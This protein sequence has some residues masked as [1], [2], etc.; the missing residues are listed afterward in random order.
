MCESFISALTTGRGQRWLLTAAAVE[1]SV[2]LGILAVPAWLARDYHAFARTGMVLTAAAVVASLLAVSAAPRLAES[3]VSRWLARDTNL[4]AFLVRLTACVLAGLVAFVIYKTGL[5]A[6]ASA[7]G[8][9][10]PYAGM[11]IPLL[12]AGLGT[13]IVG[14]G[15]LAA[16]PP[17]MYLFVLGQAGVLALLVNAVAALRT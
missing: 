4:A 3:R 14:L 17:C 16:W 5:D 10:D 7:A 1:S 9:S 13:W 12:N 11:P 15:L 2:L 8:S 6:L